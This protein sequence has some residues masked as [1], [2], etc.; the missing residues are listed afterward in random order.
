MPSAVKLREDYSAEA[1]RAL[2]R[3][4]RDVNQ[5]RRLLSL[6][7]VR[8]G[9]DRGS[10]AKMGGMDRQTLRDWVHRFNASGPEGLLDNWTDGPKPRLSEEQLAQFSTIVEAGPDRAKDGVVRWRRIDLKRVIAER[11]GV[12]FH[13]RYVGKLLKKLGFSHISARG[14]VIRR[15]TNGLSRRS[16]KL[17]T[18]AEGPSR[19]LLR[20]DP[21]RDLVSRRGPDRPEERPRPPMAPAWN[22]AQ[23]A[24]RP[25]LRQRLSVRR[26]L[27][28]SRCRSGFGVALRGHRH[29]AASPRRDLAQ[30]R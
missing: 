2:A 18:R 1:L 22:T 30:C 6:A 20:D 15:R 3:R 21:C 26:D 10:A 24:R 7:A 4:S 11:F 27:S 14:R 17:P 28:C 16:K 9:M 25:A 12:D 8:E 13:P 5:S 23:T 29:D 19:R